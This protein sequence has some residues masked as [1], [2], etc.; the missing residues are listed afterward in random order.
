MHWLCFAAGARH[1]WALI[2]HM[3]FRIHHRVPC[4]SSTLPMP[5]LMYPNRQ[6]SVRAALPQVHA[7][8]LLQ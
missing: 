7:G 3:A 8:M 4:G 1:I 2:A 5:Q 6:A